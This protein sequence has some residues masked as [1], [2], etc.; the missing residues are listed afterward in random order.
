MCM[1]AKFVRDEVCLEYHGLFRNSE[2]KTF[3]IWLKYNLNAF[4]ILNTKSTSS[5]KCLAFMAIFVAS[6]QIS[7]KCEKITQYANFPDLK[8]SMSERFDSRVKMCLEILLHTWA[9][10]LWHAFHVKLLRCIAIKNSTFNL[11]IKY[12]ILYSILYVKSRESSTKCILTY[13]KLLSMNTIFR[14]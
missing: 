6:I 4:A 10:I 7:R 14:L 8:F 12:S 2:L 1:Q 11:T 3:T 13:F 9:W 5:W